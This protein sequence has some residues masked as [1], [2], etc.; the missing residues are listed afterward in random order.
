MT[1]NLQQNL[2]TTKDLEKLVG[3]AGVTQ[4]QYRDAVCNKRDI[5]FTCPACIQDS[6]DM[7][8]AS[9]EED[10]AM[11]SDSDNNVSVNGQRQS[12]R[13][14]DNE[15]SVADLEVSAISMRSANQVRYNNNMLTAANV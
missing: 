1:L 12:T 5:P 10:A 15:S 2:K 6:M 7:V 11:Q 13:R 9:G 14:F 4:A 8:A 3:C